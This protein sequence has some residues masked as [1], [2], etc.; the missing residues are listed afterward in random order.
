MSGKT[1]SIMDLISKLPGELRNS[2]YEHIAKDDYLFM[3]LET[4][5]KA[6]STVLH[7][8]LPM[9]SAPEQIKAK[10]VNIA[11][12]SA[13]TIKTTVYGFEILPHRSVP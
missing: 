12:S 2:I 7:Y 10:Y 11:A 9:H 13:S 8:A 3:R 6:F 4:N 5:G 1:M